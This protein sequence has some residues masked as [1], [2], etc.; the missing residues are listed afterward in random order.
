MNI[1]KRLL[2]TFFLL[3]VSLIATNLISVY[4]LR[5]IA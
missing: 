5:T 2:L 4:S 3:I 1:T